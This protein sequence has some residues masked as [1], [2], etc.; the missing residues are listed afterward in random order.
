MVW[1]WLLL[2]GFFLP[3]VKCGNFLI[4]A[5]VCQQTLQIKAADF[6]DFFSKKNMWD[7]TKSYGH[8]LGFP[9]ISV[10]GTWWS[11]DFWGN[12]SHFRMGS[13]HL[14]PM[15]VAWEVGH[16]THEIW[17]FALHFLVA[18]TVSVSNSL[19]IDFVL[20]HYGSLWPM[21]LNFPTSQPESDTVAVHV[22]QTYGG[23]KPWRL[24]DS[25]NKC[26]YSRS[27]SKSWC[28]HSITAIRSDLFLFFMEDSN[29]VLVCCSSCTSHLC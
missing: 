2:W 13:I 14:N 26:T 9:W 24:N 7:V 1:V 3:G 15:G 6:V 22:S 4:R 8:C 19:G 21:D 10:S 29:H 18:A 25:Q 16:A 17:R 28:R 27:V 12:T 11:H 5:W 23:C 20:V